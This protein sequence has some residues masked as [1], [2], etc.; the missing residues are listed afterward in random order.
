MD[1]FY[2]SCINGIPLGRSQQGAVVV[3]GLIYVF[4]GKSNGYELGPTNLFN[5]I[6][7]RI[8]NRIFNKDHPE[9]SRYCRSDT[10]IHFEP[11]SLLK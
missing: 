10:L 5:T 8:Y 3:N 4:G 2:Y 7:G 6:L 11:K 1:I 9:R